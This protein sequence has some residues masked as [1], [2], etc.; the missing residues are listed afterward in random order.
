MSGFIQGED[1]S[2]ATLLPERLDDYVTEDSAVR[3]IMKRRI[4]EVDA[5][6]ERHLQ[7]LAEA[8]RQEP[9]EDKT[10]RLEDKI[11]ARVRSGVGYN[12]L[13]RCSRMKM[14]PARLMLRF[15]SACTMIQRK[16]I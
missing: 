14:Y 2:Q 5:T 15:H 4:A 8:D 16:L 7:Q 11:A 13:V 3:V 12:L 6:I 1:R 10:P 9:A